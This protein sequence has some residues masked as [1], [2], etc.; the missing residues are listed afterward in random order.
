MRGNNNARFTHSFKFEGNL[1]YVES[2]SREGDRLR[3]KL[4]GKRILEDNHSTTQMSYA[5]KE[6]RAA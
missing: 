2:A 3:K 5:F 4:E 1:K 6:A